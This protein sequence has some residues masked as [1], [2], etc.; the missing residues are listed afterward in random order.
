MA[1]KIINVGTEPGGQGDGDTL[2]DAFVKARDNFDELYQNFPIAEAAIDHSDPDIEGSIANR[3]NQCAATGG[4]TVLVGPG[5]FELASQ[6]LTVG[7]NCN[8][9]GSGK[10]ATVLRVLHMGDAIIA[11]SGSAGFNGNWSVRDFAVELPSGLSGDGIRTVARQSSIGRVDRIAISGGSV[12]SWGLRMDGV[13]DVTV[14]G[15]SY[16]GLGN[17][18]LWTNSGSSGISYGDSTISDSIIWISSDFTTGIRL[19]GAANTSR[20]V[21]NILIS[22]V[23]VS[24]SGGVLRSGTKGV[25]LRNAQRISLVHVDLETLDVAVLEESQVDGGAWNKSN[26]FIQV[27]PISCNTDY[28]LAGNTSRGLAIIGGEGQFADQQLL[29]DS[30]VQADNPVFGS[31]RMLAASLPIK[32]FTNSLTPIELSASDSGCVITNKGATGTV[33]FLLPAAR[34]DYALEYEFHVAAPGYALRVQPSAGDIIRPGQTAT[35]RVYESGVS[36]GHV[37]KIRNMD[38]QT[39]AVLAQ[40]GTWVS[41]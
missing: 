41:L 8:L 3:L 2:R 22:R 1:K 31:V 34:A 10:A 7:E 38:D 12:S 20:A 23:A 26:A 9:V 11:A 27:F 37:L 17:G 30:N 13:N 39:W 14:N 21:N 18:I 36:Y 33:T 35:G 40:Q 16:T 15:F 6:P 29:S 24:S 5:I 25:H 32:A 4:G 19:E 28:Q